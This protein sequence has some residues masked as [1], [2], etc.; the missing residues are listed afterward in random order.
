MK[1]LDD[2]SVE[3]QKFTK[4]NTPY[5]SSSGLS[6]EEYYTKVNEAV[7]K[8]FHKGDL[9]WSDYGWYCRGSGQWSDEPVG[10]KSEDSDDSYDDDPTYY[11]Y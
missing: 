3:G 7:K 10:G 6:P 1:I 5:P 9:S 8:G 2:G 11:G 4:N